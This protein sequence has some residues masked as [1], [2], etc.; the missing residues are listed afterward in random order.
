MSNVLFLCPDNAILGPMAEVCL[1]REAR[2]TFRAFSASETPAGQIHPGVERHLRGRG[3]AT[4]L[5]QPKSWQL[6][7]MPHAPVPDMIIALGVAFPQN[8][9]DWCNGAERRHW[10]LACRDRA[11]ALSVPALYEA[12]RTAVSQFLAAEAPDSRPLCA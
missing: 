12:I 8:A 4:A 7:A 1:N 10:R 6:F 5:L 3:H 9:P 11:H 2:G